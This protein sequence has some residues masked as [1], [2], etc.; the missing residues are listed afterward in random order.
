MDHFRLAVIESFRTI[1]TIFLLAMLA[2]RDA[3]PAFP[4]QILKQWVQHGTSSLW[5]LWLKK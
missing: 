5:L 3:N 2:S 4:G 1:F